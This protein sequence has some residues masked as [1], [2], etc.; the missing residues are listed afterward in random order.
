MFV[1]AAECYNSGNAN[2][3]ANAK[4]CTFNSYALVRSEFRILCRQMVKFLGQKFLVALQQFFAVLFE[5]SSG[6]GS[7]T[8]SGSNGSAGNVFTSF[9]DLVDLVSFS[10]HVLSYYGKESLSLFERHFDLVI[11]RPY[12]EFVKARETSPG[13]RNTSGNA[14][15]YNAKNQFSG[16]ANNANRNPNSAAAASGAGPGVAVAQYDYERAALFEQLLELT[17]EVIIVS[18][19]LIQSKLGEHFVELLL[20]SLS[21]GGGGQHSTASSPAGMGGM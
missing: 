7:G 6:A 2:A 3:G 17:K 10:K 21:E 4:N 8:G 14:N 12:V 9:I 15:N 19:E 16:N 11:M 20:K 13:T 1:I 5:P 18:P